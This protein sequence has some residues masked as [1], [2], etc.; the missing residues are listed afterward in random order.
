MTYPKFGYLPGMILHQKRK[1]SNSG[2]FSLIVCL[3][4]QRMKEGDLTWNYIMMPILW[5]D[6]RH[7]PSLLNPFSLYL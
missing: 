2:T 6:I 4:K 3:K 7:P 1:S 5:N